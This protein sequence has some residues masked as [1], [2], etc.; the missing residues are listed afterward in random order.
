MRSPELEQLIV[1]LREE[2][3]VTNVVVNSESKLVVV[4]EMLDDRY[5]FNSEEAKLLLSSREAVG[6]L[7]EV[8]DYPEETFVELHGME[9]DKEV[10]TE[11]E[12]FASTVDEM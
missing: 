5:E 8:L 1:D 12:E 3:P 10:M 7:F 4:D 2:K 6:R 11:L 9:I